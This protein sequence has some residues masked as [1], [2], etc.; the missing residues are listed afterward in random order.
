MLLLNLNWLLVLLVLHLL[1]E[2]LSLHVLEV[3]EI[4]IEDHPLSGLER[5]GIAHWWVCLYTSLLIWHVEGLRRSLLEVELIS[6]GFLL[7]VLVLGL[8]QWVTT[9]LFLDG[10]VHLVEELSISSVFIVPFIFLVSGIIR[11]LEQ[12]TSYKFDMESQMLNLIIDN[13]L[14]IIEREL[15]KVVWSLWVERVQSFDHLFVFLLGGQLLLIDAAHICL[16]HNEIIFV[17]NVIRDF[18]LDDLVLFS[19]F[20]YQ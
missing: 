18:L 1:L 5:E 20:L 13:K 14:S 16:V 3:L 7:G 15:A 17:L 12:D 19:L 10:L 2:L 6:K 9:E 11:V 4:G 8:L